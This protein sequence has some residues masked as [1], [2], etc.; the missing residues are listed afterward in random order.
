MILQILFPV[1]DS[2]HAEME[3][4]VVMMVMA[5]TAVSAVQAM[6]EQTVRLISMSVCQTPVEMEAPAL[7][8]F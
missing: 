5:V 3:L 1:S 4:P 2:L 8:V 7:Y 6:R